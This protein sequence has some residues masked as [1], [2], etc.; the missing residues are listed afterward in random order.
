M[1]YIKK[2]LLIFIFFICIFTL[3]V[4]A[5]DITIVI[6]PGHGGIDAGSINK[7]AGIIEKDVNL[8]ISRYLKQYLEEYANVKVIMT[9]NGFDSGKLELIDRAMVARNNNADLLICIHCNA[10]DT[11]STLNGA[12]AFVTANKSLPKYNQECTNLANKILDNISKLGIR[13]IGIKTRL[14]TQSDEVYSDGTRGDYYGIIRYSMKGVVDG[15]G[16]NI[17]NGEGIPAILVEHCYIQNG[18]EKYINNE[19]GI[20]NLAKADCNALVEYYGLRLKS[21]VV[22]GIT[23]N[24]T[25]SELALSDSKNLVATIYP[26]TAEDKKVIWSSSN[27]SIAKVDNGKVTGISE[28]EATITAKTNDGG[29]VATCKVLVKNLDIEIGNEK[30]YLLKNDKKQLSYHVTPYLPTG[31]SVKFKVQD[32]NIAEIDNNDLITSKNIGITLLE[33]EFLNEKKEKISSNNIEIDV[34]NLEEGEYFQIQN[35]KEEK[36]IITKINPQTIKT[37][38]LKNFLSSDNLEFE[39]I[40]NK[41]VIGTETRVILKRKSEI[42]EESGEILKDLICII[43][44]DVN[45]D[46]KISTMDY[47]LIKNHIMD[48]KKITEYSI[49]EAADV[50]GDGRVST[51]DYTLIKNHIM[52]VKKI[53]AR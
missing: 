36:S 47:T 48:V 29:F 45:S 33:V 26:N 9:H 52:D 25:T 8:K 39:I 44:G 21:K 38:F 28:G 16:A 22:S 15:P 31:V 11:S 1:K 46:G 13:K 53:T 14:S 34:K 2:V 50:N 4:Y 40:E 24:E 41:D 12:E 30:I 5:K 20:K 23:L 3:K 18:D 27:E 43:Y 19:N 17:Q 32:N 49:K 42:E 37:E 10:T 35:Y 6:D 7:K 51:L